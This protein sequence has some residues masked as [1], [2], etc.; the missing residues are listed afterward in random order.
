MDVIAITDHDKLD[1]ALWALD[2]A[3]DY[4]FDIVPGI[5]VSTRF[6]HVLALW[7]TTP[8]SYGLDLKETATAIREAG[9]I[10]VLAHPFHFHLPFVRRT[11]R[12]LWD[13][14]E[15]LVEA[16]LDAVEVHNAGVATPLSNWL[17]RRMAQKIDIAV[18]GDSD[19][20]NLGA[21]ATGTT[22]FP[23]HTADDL[24]HALLNRQTI[25][26]RSPMASQR[27]RRILKTR[28]AVDSRSIFGE[29]DL[30]TPDTSPLKSIRRVAILSE[31]FLPKVDGVTKTAY[32]TLRYLQETG[33]E[34]LVFAPDVAVL[35]VGASEVIRL[36]SIGVPEAPETRMA[37]PTPYVAR[38]LH[39]FKPDLIHLFR[40]GTDGSQRHGDGQA[41]KC[42]G[43]GELSDRF[44]RLC[45]S[46]WLSEICLTDAQ[47]LVT[48]ST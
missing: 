4:A 6:G 48:L 10:S 46:I 47:S 44:A 11:W 15:Q 25:A 14:P 40:S 7:V 2:H 36:P 24:R 8:I 3:K 9:G 18:T 19:A 21:I 16:G 32:L 1:S 37:L 35:N 43:C 17:A 23:G 29:T 12:E 27:L 30:V 33:R 38:R 20:H 13:N 39:D 41:P 28:L 31:A 26:E 5:E 22:H 42:P 45:A 34:V